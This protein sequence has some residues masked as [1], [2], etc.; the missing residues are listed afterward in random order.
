MKI[1]QLAYHQYNTKNFQATSITEAQEIAR[2]FAKHNPTVKLLSI[3][4]VDLATFDPATPPTP[5]AAA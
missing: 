1:Y 4:E 3:V 2:Q 5:T